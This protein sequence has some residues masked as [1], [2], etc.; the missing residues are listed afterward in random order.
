[1]KHFRRF[2][3]LWVAPLLLASGLLAA[4]LDV[5]LVEAV[6]NSD[7]V[8]IQKLLPQQIDLNASD[9]DGST[10]L[11]WAVRRDDLETA[12]LLIGR[13]ADVKTANRYSV[14]PLSLA[15]VNGN[16]AM[17]EALLKAGADPNTTLPG[18]ESALMTASR[19]GKVAAVKMLLTHGAN[20]NF[21]ESKRGQTALMWAAAEGNTSTVEELV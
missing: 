1:M 6:K 11:D 15:C 9:A 7:K 4:S 19:T 2:R 10:A 8:A 18:G 13:G 14:T 20:V 21:G 16:T 3:A 12:N 17:I 5:R